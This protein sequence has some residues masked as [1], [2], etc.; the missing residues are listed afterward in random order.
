M[1]ADP[2]DAPDGQVNGAQKALVLQGVAVEDTEVQGVSGAKSLEGICMIPVGPVDSVKGK[3]LEPDMRLVPNLDDAVGVGQARGCD[4]TGQATLQ[5]PG[6]QN[7]DLE[8]RACSH[9][10][11][12]VAPRGHGGGALR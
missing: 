3:G 8:A 2:A 11:R 5:S 4:T 12:S 7:R 1:E 6:A 10:R 9:A